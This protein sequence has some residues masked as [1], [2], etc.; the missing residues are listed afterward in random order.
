MESWVKKYLPDCDPKMFP[1]ALDSVPEHI[2][3]HIEDAVRGTWKNYFDWQS[4]ETKYSVIKLKHPWSRKVTDYKRKKT[5]KTT[6]ALCLNGVP[7]FQMSQKSLHGKK[8]WDFEAFELPSEWNTDARGNP[9]GILGEL[10][11]YLDYGDDTMDF[12]NSYKDWWRDWD[13][14]AK[15][16]DSISGKKSW[17]STMSGQTWWLKKD[18]K[19]RKR[20]FKER[21]RK[22]YRTMY[23]LCVERK[24]AE[25]FGL[26][27]LFYRRASL[28]Q[29][30]AT[31]QQEKNPN[32][33]NAKD[34]DYSF[35]E[36]MSVTRNTI[37]QICFGDEDSPKWNK[38]L[39]KFLNQLSKTEYKRVLMGKYGVINH[40]SL[41]NVPIYTVEKGLKNLGWTIED[42]TNADVPMEGSAKIKGEYPIMKPFKSKEVYREYSGHFGLQSFLDMGLVQLLENKAELPDRGK[43]YYG[44]MVKAPHSTLNYWAGML[45]N[46]MNLYDEQVEFLAF[47]TPIRKFAFPDTFTYSRW[48]DKE[49][50]LKTDSITFVNYPEQELSLTKGVLPPLDSKQ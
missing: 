14:R 38:K 31:I 37:Q 34:I 43:L 15:E 20:I 19:E 26:P 41:A 50:I 13:S 2:F 9:E 22:I 29:I 27:N 47:T 1:C 49:R 48:A 10:D 16:Y 35:S 24:Y 32:R 11:N 7:M 44:G 42:E 3:F 25:Q 33:I 8:A 23:D 18:Y 46:T 30:T 6:H 4:V 17:G 21:V 39:C 5:L 28:Y 12:Y 40:L 36:V 45:L